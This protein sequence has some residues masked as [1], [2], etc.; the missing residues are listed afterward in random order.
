MVQ[1]KGSIVAS[2][3]DLIGSDHFGLVSVTVAIGLG[4]GFLVFSFVVRIKAEPIQKCKAFTCHRDGDLCSKRNVAPCLCTHDWPDMSQTATDNEVRNASAVRVVENVLLTDQLADN[5]K[6]LID[7][8]T[9]RQKSCTAGG[10]GIYTGQISLEMS[11]LLL[12]CLREFVDSRHL[13]LRHG[14][15]L[16]PGLFA[17]RVRLM[18]KGISDPR[19][20]RIDHCLGR[21]TSFIE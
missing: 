12:D 7:V 15:K 16:L 10:Y 13:L 4:L 3:I 20:H 11:I 5:L 18:A 21:F 2:F 8:S 17:T 1:A 6:L 19:M 9:S 14:Q